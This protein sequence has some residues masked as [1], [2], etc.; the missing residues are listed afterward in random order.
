MERRDIPTT[1]TARGQDAH[2]SEQVRSLHICARLCV[3]QHSQEKEKA[4]MQSTNDPLEED[5]ASEIM[6]Q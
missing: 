2:N 6:C 3:R 4:L 5:E 1:S